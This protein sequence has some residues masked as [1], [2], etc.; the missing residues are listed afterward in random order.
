MRRFGGYVSI[1]LVLTVTAGLVL[2]VVGAGALTRMLDVSDGNVWVWSS[3]SGQAGRVN[4]NSG[5]VDQAQ[6]LLDARGHRVEV[7]QNDHYLLLHD[8]QVLLVLR[9]GR[10]RRR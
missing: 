10:Q 9:L 1:G 8:R 2:T 7:A 5:R 4:A 6:R 3:D